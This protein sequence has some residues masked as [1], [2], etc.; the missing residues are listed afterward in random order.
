MK[1]TRDRSFQVPGNV[2]VISLLLA[3]NA[4]RSAGRCK[5]GLPHQ[6]DS[7]SEKPAH[8]D[9]HII[10]RSCV[11]NLTCKLQGRNQAGRLFVTP[12]PLLR[13]SSRRLFIYLTMIFATA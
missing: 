2:G 3:H 7:N 1:A 10:R 5:F 12:F 11:I 4:L 9:D 6:F 13:W 8:I